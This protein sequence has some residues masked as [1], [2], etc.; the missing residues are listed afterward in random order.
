MS[1]LDIAETR[2]PQDGR[3]EL[4]VGGRSVDL[5][6][7]TLP[8][9]FGE[10]CVMRILDRVVVSL[11]LKNLGPAPERARPRPRPDRPPA[12]HHARHGADGLGQDD[13]A[14][15]GAQRRERRGDQDHHDRGPGR[16]RPRRH[17]PDPGQRG[18]RRHLRGVPALDPAP[19][20]RQDPGRRDPRPRDRPD[21][22]RGGAHGP[23]RLLDPAH[24]RR[25]ERDHPHGSTSASS[26]SCSRPRWRRS[27]RSASCGRSA[28][29]AGQW[30]E[31]ARRGPASSS[32]C[33]RR[34]AGDRSSPTARGASSATA[35]A[36]GGAW[37]SSR[38]W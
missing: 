29:R 3:I 36:T 14:L 21:R 9:M 20:P 33:R 13:D 4:K 27:S 26:R 17:H 16:V 23:P 25:A 35:P 31:P 19:G 10:S 30:Y 12:R 32:I 2:L 37:R 5:R 7:S 28:K 1:S 18:D 8:T 22:G 6:V 38:S 11:D 24:E 15:L 34:D